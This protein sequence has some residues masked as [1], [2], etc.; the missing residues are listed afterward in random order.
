MTR[1]LEME[2]LEVYFDPTPPFQCS[3]SIK[4][5]GEPEC[6]GDVGRYL[7][8]EEGNEVVFV[9]KVDHY[10]SC[11]LHVR[12]EDEC[13]DADVIYHVNLTSKGKPRD[14]EN[15]CSSK[16]CAFRFV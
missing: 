13:S 5:T 3:D 14:S 8:N 12:L 15:E 11:M 10:L 16:A 7:R 1:H 2:D 4:I 6:E 9:A